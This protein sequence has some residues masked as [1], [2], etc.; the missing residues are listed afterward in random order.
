MDQRRSMNSS[1]RNIKEILLGHII[2]RLLKT[3]DKEKTL[4]AARRGKKDTVYAE[5]QNKHQSR[6][7][8]R[9]IA[10]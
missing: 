10:T 6:L 7:P 1:R 4:E 8:V 5:E 9:N 3:S 2:S